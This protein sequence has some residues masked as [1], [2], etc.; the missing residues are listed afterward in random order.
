MVRD[1][2]GARLPLRFP[3]DRPRHRSSIS[4]NYC[5]QFVAGEV[6]PVCVTG[7]VNCFV[8]GVEQILNSVYVAGK[9]CHPV[10]VNLKTRTHLPVCCKSCSFCRRVTAKERCK[11]RSS[12]LN[13]VC[14]RCFL[15]KPTEFCTKCHKCPTCCTKSTC[16]GQITPVWGKMGS[17]RSQSQ[18]VNSPQGR[19][20][21]SLTVPAKS[22]KNSHN[23][24]LLCKSPQ[25]QLPVGGIASAFGQ[26]CCRVSS[27]ST[28]LGVLQ[29]ANFGT[30]TQ[31]PVETYLGSRQTQHLFEN[32]VIQ[33]GDPGDNKDLP[34][35]RGVGNLHRFQGRVLPHTNKQ[36]V[37]EVH[38]FSYPG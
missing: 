4:D 25:E 37:Q 24:K 22:D 7:Q 23:N 38:A 30:Q 28:I 19:V 6:A 14:E 34:P 3:S 15:C 26:K 29:T 36:P 17:P 18:S 11:S 33:N 21:T 20:H 1:L 32:T 35:D 16:R 31:Q 13:K 10:T 5:A 9:D 27:K 12:K 8:T 2:T